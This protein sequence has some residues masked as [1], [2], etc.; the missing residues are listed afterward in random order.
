MFRTRPGR[1]QA[2]AVHVVVSLGQSLAEL[3]AA[4]LRAVDGYHT[5]WP[6]AWPKPAPAPAP[7]PSSLT[8]SKATLGLDA[9]EDPAGRTAGPGEEAGRS[10]PIRMTAATSGRSSQ[11][12][13]SN[14]ERAT[15]LR[16]DAD[17]CCLQGS[18]LTSQATAPNGATCYQSFSTLTCVP[19]LY[20]F[21]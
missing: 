6:A 8:S 12:G 7:E 4:R 10:A 1:M 17:H 20:A 9:C 16:G 3:A 19:V 18:F 21:I 15:Q 11:K 13:P 14:S 5:S 2:S